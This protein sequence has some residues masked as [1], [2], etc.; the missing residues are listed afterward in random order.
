MPK[1]RLSNVKIKEVL[2]LKFDADLTNRQIGAS[3][4]ISH[5]TVANYLHRAKEV[6]IGWPLP[7]GLSETELER[8]LFAEPKRLCGND[9][10]RV[11]PD[12]PEIH[13]QMKR[14][15][16]TLMLL[17]QEYKEEHP[18][19]GYQYSHFAELYRQWRGTLDVVMRQIHKAGEKLFV[20][21]AG[22][23]VAVIERHSGAI[24]QAEIFVAVLG[25]SNYSYAEASWTQ[26]AP[27]WIAAHI[28]AFEFFQGCPAILVPDN[29]KS[30]VTHPHRY[31]PDLNRSYAAMAGYYGV[32]IVPA[33]VRKPKD[34]A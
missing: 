2:R 15:G 1:E 17:W 32:A 31:D 27:D 8:R 33:R 10:P 34:K 6:G 28:R 11:M 19:R 3:L 5:S 13:Q 26:Q 24:R 29:L 12:W 7:E 20:D 22:Q 21:Y 23:T 14:K 4:A 9:T 18:E 25:A 16:V 30:A